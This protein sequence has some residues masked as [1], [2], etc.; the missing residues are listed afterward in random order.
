MYRRVDVRSR[1]LTGERSSCDTS[2]WTLRCQR[3]W[4]PLTWTFFMTT[5]L[6]WC[7]IDHP[8]CRVESSR[9]SRGSRLSLATVLTTWVNKKSSHV[10]DTYD[11]P[12]TDLRELD[13]FTHWILRTALGG[14]NYH[15]RFTDDKIDRAEVACWGYTAIHGSQALK[16]VPLNTEG[17]SAGTGSEQGMRVKGAH[18]TCLPQAWVG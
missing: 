4:G 1:E 10:C 11:G 6:F 16:S 5:T 17:A 2:L 18:G 15:P 8:P 9:P 13:I 7:C 3:L 14:R 12:G